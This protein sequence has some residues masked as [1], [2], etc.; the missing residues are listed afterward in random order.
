MVKVKQSKLDWTVQ[1]D[2]LFQHEYYIKDLE[3]NK[4]YQISVCHND[5]KIGPGTE[6][7]VTYSH[8][9]K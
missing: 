6:S 9:G 8:D 2:D 4:T 7:I 1:I 3:P 5:R